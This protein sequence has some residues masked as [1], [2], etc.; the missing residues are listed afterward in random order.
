MLVPARGRCALV[1]SQVRLHCHGQPEHGVRRTDTI[2]GEEVR[3]CLAGL[4]IDEV[5]IA[6][7]SPWQNPYVERL[8]GSLRRECLNHM[9]IFSERQLR[10]V[11]R[12]YLA[13]YHQAR[14]HMA[15]ANNA[16][17]PR[18]VEPVC[19]GRV[20]AIPYLGGLH[21]RYARCA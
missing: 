12:D 20:R 3:R 16:P 11:L 6:P 18:A 14:P 17:E 1:D 8:I 4:H 13:Y 19:Q 5:I 9:I 2:Y 15:L 10:R 21:H 7:R